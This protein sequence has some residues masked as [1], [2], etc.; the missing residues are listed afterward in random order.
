[1]L[2]CSRLARLLTL[3]SSGKC[4]T[5]S[6]RKLDLKWLNRNFYITRHLEVGGWYRFCC[7][8]P[9]LFLVLCHLAFCLSPPCCKMAALDLGRKGM[10]CMYNWG[11]ASFICPSY[12]ENKKLPRNSSS[13]FLFKSSWPESWHMSLSSLFPL[14]TLQKRQGKSIFVNLI[15]KLCQP[16]KER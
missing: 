9:K 3:Y 5:L 12:Q 8:W 1:M 6:S 7:Q 15:N 2:K 14:H 4:S 10:E 13:W 11:D 16:Y